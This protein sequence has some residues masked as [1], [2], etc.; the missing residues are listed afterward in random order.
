MYHAR[1]APLWLHPGTRFRQAWTLVRFAAVVYSCTVAPL[2][3]QSARSTFTHGFGLLE[4]LIDVLFVFNTLLHLVFPYYD[5]DAQHLVIDVAAIRDH[6]LSTS[7]LRITALASTPAVL[8]PLGY[9]GLLGFERHQVYWVLAPGRMGRVAMLAPS[10]QAVAQLMRRWHAQHARG[11][12]RAASTSA[13][14]AADEAEPTAWADDSAEF[15]AVDEPHV[16]SL[17]VGS[18]C[19]C[20]STRSRARAAPGPGL[21]SHCV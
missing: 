10:T 5:P 4:W 21:F 2:W 12:R 7:E 16:N 20:S 15:A 11:R 1:T 9:H 18:Y 17:L 3:L 8:G 6:A 13:R 14:A 19:A